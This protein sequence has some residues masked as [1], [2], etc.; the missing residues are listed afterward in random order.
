M[1]CRVYILDAIELSR[2]DKPSEKPSTY[3]EVNIGETV[4]KEK[5][6][7]LIKDDYDPEYYKVYDFLIMIPGCPFLNINIWQDND[8]LKDQI[9]GTT[10]IDLEERY[11]DPNWQAAGIKPIEY[12]TLKRPTDTL[13]C[14]RLSMWVELLDPTIKIPKFDI[15]PLEKI[16][17]ELR[18]IVWECKGYEIA[19]E[20]NVM[21]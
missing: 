16:D 2:E 6:K 9:L 1:L 21:I 12:R 3:L 18:V 17:V 5:E 8:V 15:S 19:D 11:F 14:G 20:V 10:A 7:T 13:P 4:F